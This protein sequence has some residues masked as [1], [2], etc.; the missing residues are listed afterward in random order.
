MA[1]ELVGL[2]EVAELAGMSRSVVSNWRA[3]DLRFPKPV[4]DLRSGPVFDREAIERHLRR[5]RS[6]V[7]HV[8]A[9]INLKGGC[10]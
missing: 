1:E 7:A 3:R 10:W 2:A 5:R 8:I 9:T 4:A 6:H